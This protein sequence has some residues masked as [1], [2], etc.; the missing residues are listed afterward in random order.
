MFQFLNITQLLYKY[1]F[2]ENIVMLLPWYKTTQYKY[3]YL[4]IHPVIKYINYVCWILS[5]NNYCDTITLI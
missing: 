2:L 3:K 4:F 1:S 5:K